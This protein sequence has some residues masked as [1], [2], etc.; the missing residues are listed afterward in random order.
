VWLGRY[1][2][3]PSEPNQV[4][5]GFLRSWKGTMA[6]DM[7][8]ES[9]PAPQHNHAAC[10]DDAIRSARD[11]F[12]RHEM[13]FTPLREKVFREIAGSHKAIGAYDVLNSLAKKGTRLTPISVYRIINSLVDVGVVRRFKSR[14]AFYASVSDDPLSPKIV[15]ACETCGRVADADG[16]RMLQGLRRTLMRRAFSPRTAIIEV[17]GVCAHCAQSNRD[18]RP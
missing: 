18:A 17:L 4:S 16:L 2:E 9:F 13:A 14:N 1:A 15:L 6:H 12:K 7:M 8:S 10:L 3:R 5:G 11:A